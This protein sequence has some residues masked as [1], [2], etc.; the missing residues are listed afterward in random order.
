MQHLFL[1]IDRQIPI[2]AIPIGVHEASTSWV[3]TLELREKL[4]QNKQPFASF[5]KLPKQMWAK[6]QITTKDLEEEEEEDRSLMIKRRKQ[7]QGT[8]P[9][10]EVLIFCTMPKL[11]QP[12]EEAQR[13][14]VVVK[15]PPLEH[16]T[17]KEP[18]YEDQA[19][20][21][22]PL[23]KNLNQPHEHQRDKNPTGWYP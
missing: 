3:N 20:Q 7:M 6:E 10:P 21:Q 19:T 16:V 12:Q 1:D 23:P 17:K 8:L 2:E 13:R 11:Q 18:Q 22:V 14:V 4:Q 15:V 9:I 5:S